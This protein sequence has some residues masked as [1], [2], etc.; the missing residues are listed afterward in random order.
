LGLQP[1]QARSR[2]GPHAFDHAAPCRRVACHA[3]DTGSPCPMQARALG[4]RSSSTAVPVAAAAQR[5]NSG[6]QQTR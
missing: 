1:G 3:A 4:T 5:T 2:Q 6:W